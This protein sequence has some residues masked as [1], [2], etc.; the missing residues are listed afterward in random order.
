MS[1]ISLAEIG[2]V[3]ATIFV[4][5]SL[6][7]WYIARRRRFRVTTPLNGPERLHPIWGWTQAIIKTD[8]SAEMYEDWVKE[9]GS[10]VGV[11]TVFWNQ[12]IILADPKAV[13]H[14]YA[15]DPTIYGQSGL[16]KVFIANL[17]R[18]NLPYSW[19]TLLI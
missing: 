13:T 5:Y 19:I 6:G 3:S 12:K 7:S 9:F 2:V 1:T 4:A 17:V 15:N 8:Y 11:P 14:F 10:V 16:A 18:L